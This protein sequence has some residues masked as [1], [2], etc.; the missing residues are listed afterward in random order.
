[1][2]EALPFDQHCTERISDQGEVDMTPVNLV[3]LAPQMSTGSKQEFARRIFLQG[4]LLT[5]TV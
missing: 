5:R 2:S 4:D 1:M 3:P